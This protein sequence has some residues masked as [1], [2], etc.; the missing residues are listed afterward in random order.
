[1]DGPVVHGRQYLSPTIQPTEQVKLDWHAGVLLMN[2]PRAGVACGFLPEQITLGEGIEITDLQ[3]N[4]PKGMPCFGAKED[5][6]ACIGL[7]ATDGRPLSESRHAL[8]SA[9]CSSFNTGF[10]VNL[11]KFP[12]GDQYGRLVDHV[13][14]NEIAGEMGAAPVLVARVGL[15]LRAPCLAGCTYTLRDW[16][17]KE[18]GTG[19][20]GDD[21]VLDVPKDKPVFVV[22][23]ER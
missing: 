6:Y 23:L 3:L 16:H 18:I 4:V 9:M 10:T 19:K 12:E 7:S 14:V 5:L 21:G 8:L 11:D 1:M 22:E 2:S 13:P 17:F 15:T 20:I